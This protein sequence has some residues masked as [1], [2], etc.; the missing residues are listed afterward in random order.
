MGPKLVKGYPYFGDLPP[1]LLG[2]AICDEAVDETH[3]PWGKDEGGAEHG[4]T[5]HHVA[6]T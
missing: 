5:E 2:Q 6:E 4:E 1:A 3:C